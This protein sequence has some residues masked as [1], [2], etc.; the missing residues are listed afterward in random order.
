MRHD[1]S[2]VA[3]INDYTLLRLAGETGVDMGRF[4]TVKH[5]VSWCGLA[6]KSH[7]SG[8]MNKRVKG[9]SCNQAGQIF[10]ECAHGL[11]NSKYIAIGVFMR[12]VK[13]RRDSMIAIKAGARKIATA[14]YFSLTKGVEYVE[15][16]TKKY[17][18]QLKQKEIA[19]L[20]R[21][22]KKNNMQLTEIQSEVACAA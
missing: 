10:K 2:L 16:G 4:P 13:N 3:G 5:F 9:T 12:G 8:K 14:Y 11:L 18:E 20:H 6:P 15:Q 17:Q 22:A 7:Q 1:V 21:L 19:T